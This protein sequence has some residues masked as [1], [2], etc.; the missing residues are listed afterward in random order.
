MYAFHVEVPAGA[1]HVDLEFQFASPQT[2]EQGRVVATPE[3]LGLQWNT[4]VLYPDGYYASRIAIRADVKLPADW[5]FA[6]ALVV[7][8]RNAERVEF[9]PTSLRTLVDSPLFAGRF[10]KRVDLDPGA[11]VPVHLNMVAD[12]PSRLENQA[13]PTRGLP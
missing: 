2:G 6:T 10:F 11:D 1:D 4:V 7:A 8:A 9:A 13:R 5:Q 3:I 12:Q